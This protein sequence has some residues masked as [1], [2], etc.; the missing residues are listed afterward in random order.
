MLSV[1]TICGKRH[2]EP[3][4][5]GVAAGTGLQHLQFQGVDRV[6]AAEF[7]AGIEHRRKD[8]QKDGADRDHNA[9]PGN[10]EI[11]FEA[12]VR[13]PVDRI[14]HQNCCR[15]AEKKS[16]QTV[17]QALVIQHLPKTRFRK[18]DRLQHRE[19]PAPQ[20]YAR[21]HRVEHVCQRYQRY[22]DY[23]A[24]GY[25]RTNKCSRNKKE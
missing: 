22:Q 24:G 23:E 11:N 12:D 16:F 14:S 3:V 6:V 5:R 19:L 2:A 25:Y 21:G 8:Y 17:N 1:R 7:A 9:L 15:E 10:V 18:T 13:N 4:L 20:Q